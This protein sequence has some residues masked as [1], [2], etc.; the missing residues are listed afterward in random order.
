ME[1]LVQLIYERST[2]TSQE[3]HSFLQTVDFPQHAAERI[4]LLQYLES[5]AQKQAII[6]YLLR[7]AA[8]TEEEILYF[9]E[10]TE[11]LLALLDPSQLSP[12]YPLFS[13]VL[14]KY[15]KLLRTKHLSIRGLK[16]LKLALS[17][18]KTLEFS[19]VHLEFVKLCL[20][21]N[22]CHYAY[23]CELLVVRIN[24]VALPSFESI[25]EY[26][27]SCG[28]INL[29][30]LDFRKAFAF[31]KQVL[32]LP[33]V[34]PSRWVAPAFKKYALLS[35]YLYKRVLPLPAYTSPAV[36]NALRRNRNLK[37][38]STFAE[39]YTDLLSNDSTAAN[40][41]LPDHTALSGLTAPMLS[42]D[43][44]PFQPSFFHSVVGEAEGE[45][46]DHPPAAALLSERSGAEMEVEPQPH[47]QTDS[48]M[49][50][51]CSDAPSGSDEAEDDEMAS[52]PPT[53]ALAQ[54]P[55]PATA[56]AVAPGHPSDDVDSTNEED[57]EEDS[58]NLAQSR[59]SA[60]TPTAAASSQHRAEVRAEQGNRERRFTPTRNLHPHQQQQQHARAGPDRRPPATSR[61]GAASS[62][63][64]SAAPRVSD[65][66]LL[67][68]SPH[69]RH[70]M[71]LFGRQL[72]LP[73]QDFA[74]V[75]SSAFQ[76]H[77]AP[78]MEALSQRH[79][80]ILL[81][82]LQSL[83]VRCGW[84]EVASKLQLP[85]DTE[86]ETAVL[87]LIADNVVTA[88]LD[89]RS[90]TIS[91]PGVL[92][93]LK[94]TVPTATFHSLFSRTSMISEAIL[95]ELAVTKA[96]RASRRSESAA[97]ALRPD[98]GEDSL[99]AFLPRD[100]DQTGMKLVSHHDLA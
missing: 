51:V 99:V 64:S 14:T 18:F 53:A 56:S 6:L 35:L 93:P 72:R 98:Q 10:E 55:L 68:V 79:M 94:T 2:K 58:Y 78:L 81:E 84:N 67:R 69:L 54:P 83:Y 19:P 47:H 46:G 16:P 20:E 1:A 9:F 48:H 38:Y 13:S 24:S 77:N 66:P 37:P 33:V 62:S 100:Y 15:C 89:C 96:M 88:T 5:F 90:Q 63:S 32:T 45:E 23:D 52:A 71:E 91:F 12:T 44:A 34:N 86:V 42:Q 17:R 97:A 61:R 76:D 30:M 11:T 22:C 73:S 28:E 75:L 82:D 40:T 25:A 26:L 85:A 92:S 29:Q 70:K 80:L 87:K 4:Q 60:S 59:L 7:A 74:P 65:L 27:F 57:D 36:N 21:A 95:H 31:F 39:Y 43:A 49:S 3:F 41:V 50:D 8:T